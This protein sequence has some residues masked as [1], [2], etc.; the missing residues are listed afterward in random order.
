MVQLFRISSKTRDPREHMLK[1]CAQCGDGEWLSSRSYNKFE[2]NQCGYLGAVLQKQTAKHSK[3][4]FRCLRVQLALI[5]NKHCQCW[6]PT[7]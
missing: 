4:I 6:V 7:H 3:E 5:L 1:I 2:L